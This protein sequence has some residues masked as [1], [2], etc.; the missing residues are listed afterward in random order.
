MSFQANGGEGH[1]FDDHHLNAVQWRHLDEHLNDDLNEHVNDNFP[2]D[3]YSYDSDQFNDHTNE[4]YHLIRGWWRQ[5]CVPFHR[6][7]R[8]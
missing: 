4:D 8:G 2:H 3:S 6:T 7:F 5:F 1:Q